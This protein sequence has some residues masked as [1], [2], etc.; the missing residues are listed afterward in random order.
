MVLLFSLPSSLR[1]L[2]NR[3]PSLFVVTFQSCLILP[4]RD[5]LRVVGVLFLEYVG[6]R[7]ETSRLHILVGG[8]RVLLVLATITRLIMA[9][10]FGS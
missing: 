6:T 3:R 2:R 7:D 4:V 9:P 10:K 1:I 5:I 8:C